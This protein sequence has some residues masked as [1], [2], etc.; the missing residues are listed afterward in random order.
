MIAHAGLIARR[1]GGLW[2]GVLVMGVSGSGKSD[3]MLR[4]LHLGF[5]LVADDRTLVWA[6]AGRLYGRAP[7]TLSGLME[8]RGLGV[9]SH[10]PIPMAEIALLALCGSEPAERLPEPA[11]RELEGVRLPVL[12]LVALEASAAAKLGRA[13]IRL[14]QGA[15]AA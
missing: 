9:L 10:V 4:A 1:Q 3:L 12:Q 2:R 8:A 11:L 14:G 6:S 13:L 5:R 7:D 15:G